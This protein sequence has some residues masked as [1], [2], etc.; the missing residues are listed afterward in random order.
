MKIDWRT[1]NSGRTTRMLESALWHA[2]EKCR[3][4]VVIFDVLRTLTMAHRHIATLG[5]GCIVAG[6]SEFRF[7]DGGSL[8]FTIR[9]SPYELAMQHHP[10]V[11]RFLDHQV[12]ENAL[13][14]KKSNGI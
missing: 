13:R 2:Q 7:P 9:G 4:C 8:V 12:I 11:E 10:E 14:K 5:L 6:K 3:T 1:P